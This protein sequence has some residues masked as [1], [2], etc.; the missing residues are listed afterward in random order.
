MFFF[1]G[2]LFLH[3]RFPTSFASLLSNTSEI[4]D[5]WAAQLCVDKTGCVHVAFGTLRNS[6]VPVV[7]SLLLPL[8]LSIDL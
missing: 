3:V 8:C 7:G 1:S 5:M 6:P 2:A 4:Q